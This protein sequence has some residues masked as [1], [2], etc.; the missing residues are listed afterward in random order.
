MNQTLIATEANLL[1]QFKTQGYAIKKNLFTP[2]E[3]IAIIEH[4]KQAETIDGVSALNKGAMTFYSGV[5]AKSPDLQTVVSQPKVINFLKQF[6]GDNF[7][8]RW[9]QAVAKGPGA[10]VFPWHQDN[11]YNYLQD[12]HF[13]FWIALTK[14]TSEN[15]G[16]WL[17]P[18]RHQNTLP[19]KK[20]G[21]HMV[22]QGEAKNPILIEADPGDVVIF[23]SFTLH[24][25]TPNT[26]QDT[27]WAYVIEYMKCQDLDPTVVPPY[28]IVARNGQPTA[29]FVN[30]YS[31][32]LNPINHLKY[33]RMYLSSLS[34]F[35]KQNKN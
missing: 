23:S 11:A 29:E 18:Q 30:W 24:S 35:I 9:D 27:R 26:T 5:Y 17:V 1:E 3:A 22:F 33:W 15:G 32:K 21:N 20:I 14:T 28:F 2:E 31:G 12:E 7:W 10:G 16:L 19:H 4:I 8:V 6:I 34:S 25:T 13:Q